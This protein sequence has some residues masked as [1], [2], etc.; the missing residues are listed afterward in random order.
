MVITNKTDVGEPTATYII[1]SDTSYL[2]PGDDE[3]T[4]IL[5]TLDLTMELA[6][7]PGD[8]DRV[9]DIKI[10]SSLGTIKKIKLFCNDVDCGISIPP[11]GT[12]ALRTPLEEA[13]EARERPDYVANRKS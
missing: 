2:A 10:I 12:G 1:P 13:A 3:P 5:N 4:D 6:A 8:P 11:I 9:Y 7:N